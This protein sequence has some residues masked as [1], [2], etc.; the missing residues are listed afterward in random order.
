MWRWSPPTSS[1]ALIIGTRSRRMAASS[2]S[3]A[4]NS[5]S[6][7]A[8]VAS[9]SSKFSAISAISSSIGRGAVV[10]V[11]VMSEDPFVAAAVELDALARQVAGLGRAQEDECVAEL[12]G[13]AEPAGFDRRDLFGTGLVV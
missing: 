8:A 1:G 3:G 2:A 6:A 4:V 10:V 5:R 13:T 12:L 7:S 9:S 11:I